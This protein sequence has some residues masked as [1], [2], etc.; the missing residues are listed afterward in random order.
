MSLFGS[1]E[2]LGILR[3]WNPIPKDSYVWLEIEM[4]IGIFGWDL[5]PIGKGI[6]IHTRDGGILN[7]LIWDLD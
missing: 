3:N 4:G 6:S 5:I 7:P 2:S 1:L